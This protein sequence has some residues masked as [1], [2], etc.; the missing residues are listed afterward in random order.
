LESGKLHIPK[1]KGG[2]SV[3]EHR[4][5]KGEIRQATISRTP[6]GKFFVS[7]L[8]E[9]GASV[10]DKK[11]V[12][13][14]TT[15][16]IKLGLKTLIVTSDGT[17]IDDPKTLTKAMERL[18]F[19]QSR[20]SRFKGK[21]INKKLARLHEKVMNKRHD[22][23]HK[24][25]SMLVKNHDSI[26]IEDISI[27]GVLKNC[28]LYQAIQD[29]SWGRFV[30]ML[31][32]KV[33]WQGKNILRIGRFDPSSKTCS[34]CGSILKGLKLEDREW[35]CHECGVVHDRNIN[36]AKNIK[37]FA[38]AK[39]IKNF[40]GTQ[41]ENHGELSTLAEVLTHEAHSSSLGVGG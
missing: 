20:S 30:S 12:L 34:D 11:E 17:F 13:E 40:C 23:L 27:K 9:T 14:G 37:S 28:C 25:S 21:K 31:E 6:T 4:P 16:G 2:I 3:I 35:I 38:L 33:M 15:V 22:L 8:V 7:I 24:T 39:H 19:M 41:R 29:A 10:P 36:A 32:Y 26:A 1:F 5:L 18:K